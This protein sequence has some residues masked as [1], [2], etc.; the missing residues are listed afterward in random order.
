M[1]YVIFGSIGVAFFGFLVYN[2]VMNSIFI[3]E[4]IKYNTMM[5]QILII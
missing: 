4:L 1:K 2:I 3:Q 5:N